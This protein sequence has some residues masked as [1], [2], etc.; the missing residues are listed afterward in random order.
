MENFN[1]S[2]AYILN[3]IFQSRGLPPGK[4]GQYVATDDIGVFA[5]MAFAKP[6]QFLGKTI[7]LAGD[8]LTEAQIVE[9]FAKVIGRPVKLVE[10]QKPRIAATDE[11][12]KAMANFFNGIGYSA[13]IPALRA[14]YPGL[15]TLERFLRRNGWENA[16]PVPIPEK[17]G[18]G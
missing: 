16:Q 12:Q 14:L 13:D 8:E 11:E 1:R 9:V 7:E 5:E 18:W 6:D 3:G 4:T 2:R 17:S 10:G 15:Q